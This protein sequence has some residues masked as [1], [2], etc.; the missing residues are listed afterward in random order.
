MG[1]VNVMLWLIWYWLFLL[2]DFSSWLSGRPQALVFEAFF[3]RGV[4]PDN[5][6]ILSV[7]QI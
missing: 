7:R 6:L 2:A 5:P 4:M 1:P 3:K